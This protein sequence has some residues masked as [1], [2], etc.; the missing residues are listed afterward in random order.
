MAKNIFV[1][2]D[3]SQVEEARQRAAD[4]MAIVCLDFLTGRR[5]KKLQIPYIS[6]EDIIDGDTGQ[7]EWWKLSH[8]I[9][10]EWYRVPSMA[11]FTY[12]NIRLGEVPETVLQEYLARLF[13]YIRIYRALKNKY[14]DATYY[15][16]TPERMDSE[17][18][19]YLKAF[20]PWTIVDAARMLGLTIQVNGAL[21]VPGQYQFPRPSLKSKL[22]R[23]YNFFISLLPRRA[24]EIFTTAYWTFLEPVEPYLADIGIIVAESK[25]LRDIGAHKVLAHRLRV[26]YPSGEVGRTEKETITDLVG[27]YQEKWREA[28]PSIER[29]L[30]TRHGFNWE[31]LLQ[32]F[33]HLITY[34]ARALADANELERIMK[35]ERPDV[36]LEMASVGGPLNHFLLI[37]RVAANLGIPSIELQHAGATID[38]RS[39]YSRIETDYLATYGEDVNQF[40]ERIGH[41]PKRMIPVGAP[42]F[43][44]YLKDRP[45]ATTRGKTLY[46][47]LGIDAA[48]PTLL[49]VVPFSDTFSSALD[50]YELA[51]FFRDVR[52]AQKRVAGLQIVFKFRS[53]RH[54]GDMRD[55]LAE[56]FEKDYAITGDEELFALLCASDA[57][58]CNNTTTIYQVL[59]ADKPLI[60]YGW[61]EYDTCHADFYKR[62]APLASNQNE[63]IRYTE[64]LF[65][66][67]AYRT[68]R[69]SEQ[70]AFLEQYAFDGHS[71]ERVAKLLK[72]VGTT[73]HL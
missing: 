49:V 7:T 1:I 47:K 38:P 42:R 69:H 37:A 33:D 68:K 4:G 14:P 44:E 30:K 58:V 52:E 73:G 10:R 45:N 25:R 22:F 24:I 59:L 41:D 60:L 63:F 34:S 40:H 20:M 57:A 62:A 51:Q 27:G 70:K 61:K 54:I 15:F 35:H 31:P 23:I 46:K 17:N 6:R 12:K 48:R 28:R 8:D 67:S 18:R 5:L 19:Y 21:Q 55:Y 36:V 32:A 3:R 56:L 50:S 29:Y 72:Q 9:A 26:G 53:N 65:T 13:Y 71:S 64:K 11:F 43:D 66:D 2:S 39:V 16:S